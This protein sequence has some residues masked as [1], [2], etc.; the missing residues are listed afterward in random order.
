MF[1]VDLGNNKDLSI[2][3]DVAA[4]YS[5][6]SSFVNQTT[7]LGLRHI[8][9]TI[10]NALT[11]DKATKAIGQAIVVGTAGSTLSIALLLGYLGINKTRNTADMLGFK[12]ERIARRAYKTN[13]NE[14][15][16]TSVNSRYGEDVK[17]ILTTDIIHDTDEDKENY[18]NGNVVDIDTLF[19]AM[20]YDCRIFT[21]DKLSALTKKPAGFNKVHRIRDIEDIN[22]YIK[23]TNAKNMSEDMRLFLVYLRY[24]QQA[25]FGYNLKEDG[26]TK[27]SYVVGSE[28]ESKKA[29]FDCLQNAYFTAKHMLI[30]EPEGDG[31]NPDSLPIRKERIDWLNKINTIHDGNEIKCLEF[32]LKIMKMCLCIQ[33]ISPI[34]ADKL[35]QMYCNYGNIVFRVSTNSR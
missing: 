6:C 1:H 14:N 33:G 12:G 35:L 22:K 4:Y 17:N 5:A 32:M 31:T 16:R 11:N 26:F 13:G 29:L 19:N 18:L 34:C 27:A 21:V 8:E 25:F 20:F 3:E 10:K 9:N 30:V 28:Q 15:I 23:G 24:Y 2:E 7:N